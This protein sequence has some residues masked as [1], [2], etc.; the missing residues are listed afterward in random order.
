MIRLPMKANVRLEFSRTFAIPG[1]GRE[2][3]E[4]RHNGERA[5]RLR[6]GLVT[7]IEGGK[8]SCVGRR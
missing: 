7:G 8:D 6:G 1:E 3:K 5:A 4:S 2:S